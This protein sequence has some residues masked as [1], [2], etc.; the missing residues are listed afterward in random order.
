MKEPVA[1]SVSTS[2]S[3]AAV[4]AGQFLSHIV[5]IHV[6][7]LES[8]RLLKAGTH[9]KLPKFR[10]AAIT[11]W[12]FLDP[13]VSRLF[14][15]FMQAMALYFNVF[16]LIL[17]KTRVYWR[18]THQRS[19]ENRPSKSCMAIPADWTRCMAVAIFVVTQPSDGLAP[20]NK[21]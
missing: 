18:G 11:R 8:A 21:S 14:P 4:P 3:R 1:V 6:P 13:D 7:K 10:V 15:A 2:C 16:A 12:R 17:E 19:R 9:C 5:I 20:P